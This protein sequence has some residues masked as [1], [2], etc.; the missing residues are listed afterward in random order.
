MA[1]TEAQ[2][3]SIRELQCLEATQKKESGQRRNRGAGEVTQPVTP[4]PLDDLFR[5]CHNARNQVA[6]ARH[7]LGR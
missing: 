5:F 1:M 4:D 2:R 6:H 7:K 3:R